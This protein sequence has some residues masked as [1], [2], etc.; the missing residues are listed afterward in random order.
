M[1]YDKTGITANGSA[2]AEVAA[3]I[4]AEVLGC[5]AESSKLN[6]TI[7]LP[8][9]SPS[10]NLGRGFDRPAW[11]CCVHVLPAIFL[12]KTSAVFVIEP[13]WRKNIFQIQITKPRTFHSRGP[14]ESIYL[15]QIYSN[16]RYYSNSY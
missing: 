4:I 9:P 3:Y 10:G 1:S 6:R 12:F 11:G 13:R 15:V 16:R 2:H 14:I 8:T 5:Q 7:L